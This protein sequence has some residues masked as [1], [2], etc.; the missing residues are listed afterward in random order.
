MLHRRLRLGSLLFK[1]GLGGFPL[2]LAL[3]FIPN[4]IIS[5]AIIA[6]VSFA[7]L[8]AGVFVTSTGPDTPRVEIV[9]DGT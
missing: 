6:P 2:L 5:A 8:F 4:Q 9:G 1:V 7:L 3:L